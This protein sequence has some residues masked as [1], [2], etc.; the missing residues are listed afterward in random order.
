M[1]MA[2]FSRRLQRETTLTAADLIWPVF[3]LDGH[4]RSESVS[5]MPGVERLSIDRLLPEIELAVK[6]GIPA[7]ALFIK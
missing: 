7:V 5:S 2:D 6:L 3:I 1:R 4:D